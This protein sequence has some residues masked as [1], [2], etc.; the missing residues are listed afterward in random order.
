ML[1]FLA[2]QQQNIGPAQMYYVAFW[3]ETTLRV[4]SL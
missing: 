2:G 1:C 3:P 4:L